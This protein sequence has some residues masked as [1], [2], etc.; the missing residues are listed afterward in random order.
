M[1][2]EQ[3]AAPQDAAYWQRR[4]AHLERSISEVKGDRGSG[5]GTTFVGILAL[6]G[7]WALMTLANIIFVWLWIIGGIVLVSGLILLLFGGKDRAKLEALEVELQ[8][9]QSELRRAQR[10]P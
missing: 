1:S 2:I 4:I 5:L 9:A 8:Q 6:V 3:P 10:H 7:A